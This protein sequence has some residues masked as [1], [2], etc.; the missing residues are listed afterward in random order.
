MCGVSVHVG[1]ASL[2]TQAR[3]RDTVPGCQLLAA[4]VVWL[5][6]TSQSLSHVNTCHTSPA[7]PVRHRTGSPAGSRHTPRARRGGHCGCPRWCRAGNTGHTGTCTRHWPGPGGPSSSR[8]PQQCTAVEK[9][10]QR[11]MIKISMLTLALVQK[12]GELG[13]E[14]HPQAP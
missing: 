10:D 1:V 5:R 14:P 6:I 7:P 12:S 9:L 2:L 8:S 13:S 4:E 11:L 3:V